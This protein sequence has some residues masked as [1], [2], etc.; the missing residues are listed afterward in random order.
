[1][2]RQMGKLFKGE[3]KE[4]E[5]QEELEGRAGITPQRAINTRSV[6][7][8]TASVAGLTVGSSS[9]KATFLGAEL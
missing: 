3:W 2:A 9:L 4:P 5:E 1:M 6:G 8:R 7:D